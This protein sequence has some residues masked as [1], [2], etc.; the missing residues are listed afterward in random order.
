MAAPEAAGCK[1]NCTFRGSF[2]EQ[3]TGRERIDLEAVLKAEAVGRAEA[4]GSRL[5]QGIHVL[6]STCDVDCPGQISQTRSCSGGQ[7][8]VDPV[9][10][11]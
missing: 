1:V 8:S 5:L 7:G 11:Q 10:S 6:W 4:M 2:Q 3:S 9:I